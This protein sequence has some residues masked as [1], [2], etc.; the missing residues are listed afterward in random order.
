[1]IIK[2]IFLW[3][4]EIFIECFIGYENFF[5]KLRMD[6]CQGEIF[7]HDAMRWRVVKGDFRLSCV[8]SNDLTDHY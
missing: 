5:K 1:M 2:M 8:S 6:A 7:G 4:F 3:M